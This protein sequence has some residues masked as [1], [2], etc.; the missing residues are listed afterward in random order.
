MS[1]GTDLKNELKQRGLKYNF[2]AEAVGL[3]PKALNKY[4]NGYAP[5]PEIKLRAICLT[6]GIPLSIFGLSDYP[7]S[8]K[9][10]A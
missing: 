9:E 8:R 10:S 2:V 1:Y 4:L 5:M 3:N 6:F 7:G